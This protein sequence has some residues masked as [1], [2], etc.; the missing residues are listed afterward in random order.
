[1]I[2]NRNL[3]FGSAGASSPN[4]DKGIQLPKIATASLPTAAAA[5]A[6]MIVYDTTTM[7]IKV[8]SNSSGSYA[9][10]GVESAA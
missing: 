10:E 3:V 2:R 8:C 6:G 5:Y 4:L 9:W 1:M 7:K